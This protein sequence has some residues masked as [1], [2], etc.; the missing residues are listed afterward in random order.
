MTKAI[1]ILPEDILKKGKINFNPIN[2]NAYNKTIEQEK[3][4]FSTQDFVD[5]YHDMCVLREFETILDKIKKEGSY[6]D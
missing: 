3:K 1:E 4:I 2:L 5:I 6:R